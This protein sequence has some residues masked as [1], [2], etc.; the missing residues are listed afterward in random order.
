DVLAL[1]KMLISLAKNNQHYSVLKLIHYMP[2]Q[3]IRFSK[4]S[5]SPT[6]LF[7]SGFQKIHMKISEINKIEV[8][9]VI[10]I[11][12]DKNVV[13]TGNFDTEKQDLMILTRKKGAYIR[14]DVTAK[15]DILVEGVQDDKYKD[16][17]GLVSKQRKAREYVGNGAK[18]QFLNEEDLINLIKE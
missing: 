18:I 3:Y 13:F 12:K 1:S 15:T 14:S 8:E 2:K 17:N 16:V 11:L 4:Y 9:S 6:K 7:D 5:N 10:P